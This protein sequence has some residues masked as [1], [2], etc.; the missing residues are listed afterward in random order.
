LISA[1]LALPGSGD[2]RPRLDGG[3]AIRHISRSSRRCRKE[4]DMP[5]LRSWKAAVALA[6]LLLSASPVLADDLLRVAVTGSGAWDSSVVDF[7]WRAGIFKDAG[8]DLEISRTEGSSAGLQAVVSNSVDISIVGVSGFMGAALKGAPLKM[9]SSNFRGASDELWFVRGDSPVKS[10]K[11]VTD[12]MTLGCLTPASFSFI[13]ISAL[14]EQY[15]VKGKVVPAGSEA[16]NLTGVMTGQLD[17]GFDGNGG[18]GVPEFQRGEVRIIAYGRELAIMQNVT[19]RGMI[20]SVETLAKRRDLL[21]RYLKAYQKTVDWMYR[22]PKAIEWYAEE[23]HASV[24]DAK[25]AIAAMYPESALQVGEV[26][27]IATSVE[28][29]LRYKR[30]AQAPTAEQLAAMFDIVWQPGQP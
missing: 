9:F 29:G 10:L 15:G 2:V 1:R 24:D 21:V 8:I 17:V 14:L 28:L 4:G 25:R 16:A 27:G 26:T 23:N 6:G 19:A 18:L 30:I 11:D 12:N 20:A 7:G 3:E 5:G 22:D 13:G